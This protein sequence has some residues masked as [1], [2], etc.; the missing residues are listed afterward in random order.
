MKWRLNFINLGRGDS[1]ASKSTYV[2][3]ESI[4]MLDMDQVIYQGGKQTGFL[5]CWEMKQYT[6]FLQIFFGGYH[7]ESSSYK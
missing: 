6:F 4:Q 2:H 7:P 3:Q 5:N 1:L